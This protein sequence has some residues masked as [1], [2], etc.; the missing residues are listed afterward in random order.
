MSSI[1][2]QI[3]KWMKLK[4]KCSVRTNL[5]SYFLDDVKHL[6]TAVKTFPAFVHTHLV[7]F[8]FL[9]NDFSPLVEAA[10]SLQT[11]SKETFM[12]RKTAAFRKI[13]RISLNLKT[14]FS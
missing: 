4:I 9:G 12:Q 8:R 10:A 1:Q 3:N 7:R 5:K 11:E 2:V 14:V 13:C 6:V